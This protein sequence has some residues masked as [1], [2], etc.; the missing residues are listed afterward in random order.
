MRKQWG[1][2]AV[3]AALWATAG[4]LAGPVWAGEGDGEE[5]DVAKR[6]TEELKPEEPVEV[7]DKTPL[8]PGTVLDTKSFW[9]FRIVR[10]AAEVVLDSG[11]V[12]HSNDKGKVIRLPGDTTSD[13]ARPEFED[14]GWARLRGP[15]L[16]GSNDEDWKLILMRGK[17][18][19]TDPARAGDLSLELVFRGG[20]V[21]YLNGEEEA[22]ASMPKGKLELYAPAE[23]YPQEAYF[24]AGGKILFPKDAKGGS[25]D[26]K[27]RLA[28]R[29]RRLEGCKIPAAKLRK[30]VNVLAV[31]ISRAPTLARCYQHFHHD[32]YW[33]KIGLASIRLS[34]SPGAAVVAN[35]GPKAGAG[36]TVWNQS[37]VQKAGVS[38]YPDPFAPLSPVTISAVPNGVF[39]GQVVVGDEK[40][41]KGLKVAV[42]ELSGPGTIPA[43]AVQVRY[44]VLDGEEGR[45]DSLE[46]IPPE[47]V[48]VNA[49]GGRSV[50]P[51]WITVAP[52]GDAREG[53][54][55]GTVTL[56]AAGVKPVVVPLKVRVAGWKL[57]PPSEFSGCMDI[58]QS[59]ESVAMAYDVPL[60][61]EDHF[62][63]LDKS[64]ALLGAL[65]NK[66]LFISCIRRTH[67]G[68]EHAM[69]RWVRG[70][71]DELRPDVSVAARY[72]DT[73]MKHMGKIPGV[74]LLCWEPPFSQGHAH[75]AGSAG[76]TYDKTI[77]YSQYD[78]ATKE[79]S[80]CQG[81][82]WST[83]EAKE[84]WNK[85]TDGI[86][87]V[88]EK[89]GL[90]GSMLFGLIGDARP[91]K[92]AMDDICNGVPGAKWAV[93]SHYY[94]DRWQGYEMG[95]RIALWGLKYSPEDPEK[96][97]SFGWSNPDWVSYYPREMSLN[98]TLTE[99]RSKLEAY[100][101]ARRG[102]DFIAKGV[103]PRGLGRLGAD[104][105]QVL[106]D[107]SGRP[108]STLA[109]RYPESA[110]GQLNLNFGVPRILGMGKR[111]PVPTVRSEA[112]REAQQEV[113][114]RVY[115]EKALLD[116]NGPKR[117]GEDL[118]KRCREALDDRIRIVNR[119]SWYRGAREA[120][121]WY[122]GSG[123]QN[124]TDLL[125]ALA[126][127]V[128]AKYGDKDPAP[129]LTPAPKD[130]KK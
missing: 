1:R 125:F 4:V 58:I 8:A 52:P 31:A 68:N 25:A 74:I 57:P 85:L 12:T 105:W 80:A 45:F 46:E 122:I 14:G 97:Y 27:A 129:N 121:A 2:I 22:R 3:W 53:E 49:S 13:W 19:V 72:L 6:L 79:Y 118:I 116:D 18:E 20:A 81:P 23:A 119:A 50:Q 32:T 96:G 69:V 111:G 109:G 66:T 33:A 7:E 54:Y 91:T 61:S 83:P 67:F 76:R 98:S 15:M 59:P 95:M 128:K 38:D 73:A 87:P 37:V 64:F 102:S 9:R 17:F 24:D 114:A 127:E 21:V 48:A 123:W 82:S 39:S 126:A 30:G 117:L 62:K 110:W 60:W 106:K 26:V 120:E 78:P 51:L 34:S 112:F 86:Q 89:R 90:K 84:F 108:R 29:T 103:G 28:K 92:Q 88:L 41:I 70:E 47:E 94:V 71:D 107:G 104:F 44:A 101:G 65:G 63:L 130:V 75:G 5:E 115:V 43:L 99:H 113:E 35:I 36:F 40:P 77:L 42:S 10:E 55:S 56:T 11:E 16:Y 124:R 100:I 93:H